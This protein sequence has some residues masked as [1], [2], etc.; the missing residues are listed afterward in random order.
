MDSL[1][2]FEPLLIIQPLLI[3][4]P[5]PVAD[6]TIIT[7]ETLRKDLHEHREAEEWSRNLDEREPFSVLAC[8]IRWH[9]LNAILSNSD[10][11]VIGYAPSGTIRKYENYV[12][13]VSQMLVLQDL[14][15]ANTGAVGSKTSYDPTA[16]VLAGVRE[17]ED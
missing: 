14:R 3:G 10:V 11:N 13:Y 4:Q 9:N 8:D 6:T 12:I 16:P 15:G 2:G 5:D 1:I 7:L 17:E